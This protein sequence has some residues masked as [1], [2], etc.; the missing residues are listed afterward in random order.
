MEVLISSASDDPAAQARVATFLQ[1]LR[2]LG[3]TDG[4]NVGID[5]RWVRNNTAL[6]RPSP[7]QPWG[8]FFAALQKSRAVLNREG[9]MSEVKVVKDGGLFFVEIDGVRIARR[10]YPGTP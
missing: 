1:G 4:R 9:R 3:W 2:Q 5:T 8:P 10:G 7:P 6:G